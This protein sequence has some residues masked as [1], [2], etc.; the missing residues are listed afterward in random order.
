MPRPSLCLALEPR[1]KR[2]E[3]SGR[4]QL[5]AEVEVVGAGIVEIDGA[6]HQTQLEHLGVIVEIRLSIARQSRDMV[7]PQQHLRS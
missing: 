3:R 7:Q 4:P 5:I 2:Q 6:L 1:E